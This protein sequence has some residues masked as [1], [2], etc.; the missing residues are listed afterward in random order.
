VL[1][2]SYSCSSSGAANPI[3]YLGTFYSSF[4]GD[5]VLS[6]V[7]GYEHP[8]LY[9]SGTDIASQETAILGSSQQAIVDIHNSVWVW[10]LYMG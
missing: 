9:L 6:A 1:V 8:P 7:N 3:S 4:I 5:T 2:S 10:S